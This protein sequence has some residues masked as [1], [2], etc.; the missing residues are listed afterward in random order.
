V[1]VLK[2]RQKLSV[3]KA[4]DSYRLLLLALFLTGF[5]THARVIIS[6][7]LLIEI[8][9][10]FNIPIGLAGQI[11][12]A[13][14]GTAII[15]ALI[16]GVLTMK[17]SPRALLLTGMLI[18][19]VSALGC[20]LS[21]TFWTLLVAFSL[22]GAG[23]AMVFPMLGTVIGETLPKEERSKGIGLVTTGQP[24]SFVIGTPLVSYIASTSGWKLTF[25]A[26]MLPV[27]LLSTI[28]VYIG[29][30]KQDRIHKDASKNTLDGFRG[31]LRSRS[32][33]SCLIGTTFY[34]AS[35]WTAFSFIISYFRESFSMGSDRASWL[36][37]VLTVM[38]A[39]GS[40]TSGSLVKRIGR[41]KS[42]VVASVLLGLSVIIVY[43]FGSFW[44]CVLLALAWGYIAS[45]GYVSGD[46]LTLDQVPEFRG[47]L[48][49]LNTVSR[50][51]GAMIG[52]ILGG[53]VL[54]SLDYGWFGLAMGGIAFFA[55]LIYGVFASDIN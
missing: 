26:Y 37:S 45:Y 44:V 28:V 35:M 49:S 9:N 29:V 16:M 3:A 19:M 54:L 42:S 8:G 36:L 50:S 52:A 27:V 39:I 14:A 48:M 12:S 17:Y 23:G 7:L 20:F 31:V 32:A 15:V 6:G 51:V 47:T 40:L 25:L 33:L 13:A 4:K 53:Y 5:A 41:Q 43:N 21:P 18:Y 24:V 34:Q 22:N 11:T 10:T 30:P 55:A 1:S 2:L 46:S 38:S